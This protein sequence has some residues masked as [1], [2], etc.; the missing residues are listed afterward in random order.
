M[1][2]AALTDDAGAGLLAVGNVPLEVSAH[3]YTDDDFTRAF[4]TCELTRRDEITLHL[5]YGVIRPPSTR[6]WCRTGTASS[7]STIR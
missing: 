4:D 5:D 3:H 2:W 1:R 6:D 7:V